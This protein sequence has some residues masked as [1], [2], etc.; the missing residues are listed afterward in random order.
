MSMTVQVEIRERIRA[1]GHEKAREILFD[2]M[3]LPSTTRDDLLASMISGHHIYLAGPPGVGKTMLAKRIVQL[4]SPREVVDDCPVNCA[5]E[6]PSCPWCLERLTRGENLAKTTLTGTNRVRYVSGS[7]ELKTA[8]LI[9]DFNPLQALEFGVLDPR[10]FVPG[11]FLRANGGILLVD[12]IDRVPERVLNSILAGLAG[13]GVSIGNRDELFPL[14]VLIVATGSESGLAQM[15]MDL[16]DH[17][18]RIALDYVSDRAFERR[19]VSAAQASADLTEPAL[20][21][22]HKTRHHDDLSRGVSN[23]GTLRYGELLASCEKVLAGDSL[24]VLVQKASMV[25]L[26]HRVQLASHAITNRSSQQV[27]REITDEALGISNSSEDWIPLSSEKM[28]AIVDEIAK[29][30]HFRKP[31]KFGLFDLLLKRVKRFPESELAIMHQQMVDRMLAKWRDRQME[32]NLTFDLLSDIDETRKRQERLSA[33]LRAKLEAEALIR[34]VE[35]L[36]E[37]QILSRKERGYKLSRRG[38]A[39]LLERLAPRVWEGSQLTGMGKHRAGKKCLVGEGRIVGTRPWRFGDCY[40]DFSL[41]DTIRQAIRNRHRQVAREDIR[42]VQRD[43]RTRLNILL[44]LDLSGTMDQLEKLWYAKE[45]AIALAMASSQYGDRMGVVTFSNL[46]NVVADLTTNTYLL[47][48]KVLDLDLHD[49]A[50][51]NIGFGLLR[52]RGLFARHSKSR[53]KQHIILVSDGDATAPHPSPAR[54]AIQ[55][56]AKTVRKGISISCICINEKNA[57]PDLMHKI[58]RIGRG[59]MTVIE[60][61]EGMKDAVVEERGIAGV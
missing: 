55:E 9:G 40:R 28:L 45:G 17:F 5:I 21:I 61:T 12:F 15:P 29:M 34:T 50:F 42:V 51:T 20:K 41:K 26:P 25:A 46:A 60:H 53:G 4:L 30:D 27:I 14:D 8:D 52:A 39:L 32:D 49:N 24:E 19:L 2:G 35:Q 38:I 47:T 57:D 18:D 44:C 59:R 36:E 11:K 56:A 10:A 43:I 23:R 31:L 22:V 16:A 6:A 1:L 58:A 33:E 37:R 3:S 7:A 13:D 48:E 54:F